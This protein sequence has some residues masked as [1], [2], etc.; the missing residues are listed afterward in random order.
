MTAEFRIPVQVD[1]AGPTWIEDLDLPLLVRHEDQVFR[2]FV[3]G[4]HATYREDARRPLFVQCLSSA[5]PSAI[6]GR[7]CSTLVVAHYPRFLEETRNPEVDLSVSCSGV[8]RP[9]AG[10]PFEIWRLIAKQDEGDAV[11][12]KEIE[13]A[14]S[15]SV[16][17]YPFFHY[18][19][20]T[21]D[22]ELRRP[23]FHPVHGPSGKTITQL[24]EVPGKKVAHFHHTALWIAHQNWT[25]QGQ[26]HLDNWQ[27]N[28]NCTKIEHVKFD[29][30]ESGPLAARFIEQLSWL[31][32]KGEKTLL[33]ETRTV[34]VPKRDAA[35]RI[36][37]I[38]LTLKAQDLPVTL[39]KTPYHLLA[40]RVLD[41]MLPKNGGAIVNSDGKKN[42]QDGAP[43]QWIDISGK[44]EDEEQGVALFN[45]PKNDRQPV[46]CLQFSGQTI[47]LSPTHKEPLTIEA[48]KE[49]RFRFRV[50]VHA[51]DA[52]K[53]K[54]AT[55]YEAYAKAGQ[56]RIGGVERVRG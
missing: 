12:I 53:A 45:H 17:T 25:A 30:I 40:C 15:I 1:T 49:A 13:N 2:E 10:L 33:A 26:G 24:G 32:A 19:Y 31:D 50:L 43:A 39:H 42:P 9:P 29:K 36:I 11:K 28:K 23:I 35:S 55:E 8:D 14:L 6:P 41:A 52:E 22:P 44:L 16:A 21:K 34:T 37:D 46:P 20:N 47:G 38:D 18:Q 27:M 48:G 5:R 3:G 56:A 7:R 4:V 54:V 51:G